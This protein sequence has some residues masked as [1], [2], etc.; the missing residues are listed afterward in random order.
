M[1]PLFREINLEPING[2]VAIL[3]EDHYFKFIYNWSH[4]SQSWDIDPMV[5]HLFRGLMVLMQNQ[6][7]LEFSKTLSDK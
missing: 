6:I 3:T 5:R 7:V 1:Y 2:D 4:F